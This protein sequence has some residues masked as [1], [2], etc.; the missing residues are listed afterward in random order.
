MSLPPQRRSWT[1]AVLAILGSRLS[2]ASA[3]TVPDAFPTVQAAIDS[4]ADTVLIR[5]GSYPEAPLAYRG[6]TLRGIG[7]RRPQLEGLMISNASGELARQWR[8][9]D[10]DFSGSVGISTGNVYARGIHVD[11]KACALRSGLQHVL[12]TDPLDIDLLSLSHCT[13]RGASGALAGTV[14]MQ[15]DTIEAGV[16][17]GVI[18]TLTVRDCWF[19]GGAGVAL[20]IV[21]DGLDGSITHN[22]IERYSTGI[23]LDHADGVA[24]TDNTI[25]DITGD[26]IYVKGSRAVTL[27]NNAIS[28]C[29]FGVRGSSDLVITVENTVLRCLLGGF[30]FFLP[31]HLRAE[32]N[33][34][35]S[36]GASA[37]AVSAGHDAVLSFE[38]NTLFS[39]DGTGI[40]ILSGSSSS[41]VAQQNI[42]SNNAGWGLRVPANAFHVALGCNAWFA[43]EL[44]SVTGTQADTAEPPR[45]LRRALYVSV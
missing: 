14:V 26:G 10:I 25:R 3:V 19:T 39:N 13:L 32:R 41:L 40:D 20:D 5:D 28:D 31:D 29:G 2:L 30:S 23:F 43:N 38:G 6:I 18:D 42:A 33:I 37:F 45:V 17:W 27:S 7:V 4:G 21:G 9:S 44:G 12:S 15:S 35:G 8:I 36:C 22:L 1:L 34:V 11:F 16:R 24:I